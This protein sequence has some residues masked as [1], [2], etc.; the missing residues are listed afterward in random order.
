MDVIDDLVAEMREV[1]D[2]QLKERNN[3]YYMQQQDQCVD[4]AMRAQ[5]AELNML[6]IA[7]AIIARLTAMMLWMWSV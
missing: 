4:D 3:H 6:G 5:L 1:H 2:I 7:T